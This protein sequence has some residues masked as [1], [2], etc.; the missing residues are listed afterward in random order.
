M[1][2][3]KKII[4]YHSENL[5]M[6]DL[7]KRMNVSFQRDYSEAQREDLRNFLEAYMLCGEND[8]CIIDLRNFFLKIRGADEASYLYYCLK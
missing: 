6:G 4:S 8:L 7:L 5:Q 3:N 2:S 1:K